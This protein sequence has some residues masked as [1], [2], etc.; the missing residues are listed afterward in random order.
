MKPDSKPSL[1]PRTR[2]LR[3]VVRENQLLGGSFPPIDVPRY[4][5]ADI[6]A[7]GSYFVF[8]TIN[9]YLF[10]AWQKRKVAEPVVASDDDETPSEPLTGPF[11]RLR[12]RRVPRSPG[13]SSSRRGRRAPPSAR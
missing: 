5:I 4:V 7:A 11:S 2:E 3:A 12:R 10:A 8:G 9:V 1:R 6:I 13:R